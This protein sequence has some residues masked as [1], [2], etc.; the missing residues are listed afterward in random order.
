VTERSEVQQATLSHRQVLV[1]FTGVGLGMLLASLDQ[2]IV[3]TAMPTIVGE[4]GGVQ[5]Y[6]WPMTAYLLTA[7]AS[8]PLYGKISDLYGRKSVFQAGIVIFL[9]GSVLTG[10]SQNM[11]QLSAFRA[12]QGAGAGGLLALSMAIVGDI[13]P[14]RERGRYQGYLG[15]VFALATVCGPLIGGFFVDHLSWRWVF[16]IN[17]PLGAVALFVTGIVLDLPFQR[18]SHSIDY[19][20]SSLL[21]AA[22]SCVLLATVWGGTEYP[23]G[24]T[25]ILGL[26]GTGVVLLALFVLQELR[27]EEPILPLR[28]FTNSIVMVSCGTG[29]ILGSVMFGAMAF[30]AYFLQIVSGASPTAAGL[31]LTPIMGGVL[32]T[33]ILSGR[34][35]SRFGRYRIY[36]LVGTPVM[37]L[38]IVLL[39]RMDE[40]TSRGYVAASLVVLGLGMGC[41]MQVLVLVAQNAV[42]YR[43]LGTATAAVSF[44]RS[45]G[46]TFGVAVFGAILS[47]RLGHYLPRLVPG[48]GPV[49]LGEM[50]ASPESIR[51][52]PPGVRDGVIEAF[53]RSIHV[54][55]LWA[56]PVA[57]AA[58]LLVLLLREIPLRDTVHGG[59]DGMGAELEDDDAKL[60]PAKGDR[61]GFQGAL[62]TKGTEA[63]Q[64]SH[65]APDHGVDLVR[66]DAGEVA[67][68]DLAGVR[69]GR[70]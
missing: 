21:V 43:D 35:I 38:A 14:P 52:L 59:I 54:V 27:A 32:V 48:A 51:A 16:Y 11:T 13:V 30:V 7:T 37:A 50:Q 40:H 26:F 58:F 55:F 49:D 8:T 24:S 25:T 15:S 39:S 3:G 31:L 9:I 60:A 29:F 68:D 44:F 4:L 46:G 65:V 33:S 34:L 23:W 53:S 61:R 69:P 64:G 70:I 6:S 42:H 28:L 1:V 20:G 66:R 19:L 57:V 12:L 56:I 22:V 62:F 67:L 41:I 10:L 45:M 63:V 47:N 5:H 2:T 17:L 36:P 18:R